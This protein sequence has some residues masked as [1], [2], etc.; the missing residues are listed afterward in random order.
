MESHGQ[1]C[2][3]PLCEASAGGH[4][5]IVAL[6]LSLGAKA[7]PL[8][9][10]S[11][12]LHEAAVRSNKEGKHGNC[13]FFW[14]LKTKIILK[15]IFTSN[16]KTSPGLNCTSSCGVM[17]SIARIVILAY[18]QFKCVDFSSLFV[19]L[20]FYVQSN[21]ICIDTNKIIFKVSR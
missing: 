2:S 18:F 12:P 21:E 16:E 13:A 4:L 9:V 17:M 10:R 14:W 8:L 5:E 3:T 19:Q 15:I 1:E 20:T 6:L 7:N 11:T